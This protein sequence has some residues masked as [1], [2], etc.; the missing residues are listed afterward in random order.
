[1]KSCLWLLILSASAVGQPVSFDWDYTVSGVSAEHRD[2][3]LFGPAL[4]D[5]TQSLDALLDVQFNGYGIT[6][7]FAAK[8]N[9]LYRSD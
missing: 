9:H 4:R 7:L 8:G 1:M 2:S 3:V 6:G 5:N